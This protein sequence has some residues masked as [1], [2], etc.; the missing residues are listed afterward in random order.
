MSRLCG[1][2]VLAAAACGLN[3]PAGAQAPDCG[4]SGGLEFVCGP[5]NAEDLVLVPGTRWIIASSMVEGESM[6][7]IDSRSKRWKPLGF[8]IAPRD[9]DVYPS[10]PGAPNSTRLSTHGLDLRPGEDGHST[11]YAVGHG[12]REAIEVFDVDA[13]GDEPAVTW[14]GCVPMP[15][16]LEANSVASAADGSIVATVL[17]LPGKT[18]ADSVAGR[19]TGA[20][21]EWAPGDPEFDRVAGTEL[22]ADNGIALSVDG[23][24]MFVVSSGLHTVVAFSRSNPARQLRSTRPLPFTPDNVHRGGDGK[25]ITAGMIDD[26]PACGGKPGPQHDLERLS[27]CPRGTMAVVIDPQTM[28]DTALVERPANPEFS[29]ATMVLPV[30]GE[31]WVGTF[32]GDRV[33]YGALR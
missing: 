31:F 11:L 16:G 7:L 12:E 19:P 10:C 17:I 9:A 29:N 33:A 18:F 15:D 14:R 6:A 13:T 23:R 30:N 28:D 25:L 22:P 1:L 8:K 5:K 24:E 27:T 32:S 2:A 21:F 20:V 3:A 4:A 26:E